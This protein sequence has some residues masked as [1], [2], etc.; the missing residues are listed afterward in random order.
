[1]PISH[2]VPVALSVEDDTPY[3]HW[4]DLGEIAFKEAFFDDTVRRWS[5]SWFDAGVANSIGR[6]GNIGH[7]ARSI[8]R[9]L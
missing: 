1:M 9:E 6:S 7:P 4:G 8:R 3:L 5:Q 2:W